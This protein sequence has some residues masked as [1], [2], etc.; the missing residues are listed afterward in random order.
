MIAQNQCNF[1]LIIRLDSAACMKLKIHL[2]RRGNDRAGATEMVII[3]IAVGFSSYFIFLY[4][5]N[6]IV[7]LIM[8]KLIFIDPGKFFVPWTHK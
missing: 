8:M 2:A 7:L 6:V 1:V 5:Q 4:E 3:K